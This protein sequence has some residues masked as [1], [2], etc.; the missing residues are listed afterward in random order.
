MKPRAIIIDD[1]ESCREVLSLILRQNGY[2]T[3]SFADPAACPIYV[4]PKCSC[5]HEHACGDFLLTDNQ[6]PKMTGLDFV[7]SQTLRG[8]K[9]AVCNKAIISGT[10]CWE[11]A[12]RAERIGCKI[13]SKPVCLD[14]LL[15][16]LEAR[17]KKI[18][19]GRKLVVYDPEA[20][21][22]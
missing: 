15:A 11:E 19:P 16:W 21:G 12:A 22:C 5:P 7:E 18:P 1:D 6:M 10:L 4:D 2:E 3:F 9:G 17:R 8:C 14:E 13:F 20:P